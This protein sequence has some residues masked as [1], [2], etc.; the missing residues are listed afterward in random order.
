MIFREELPGTAAKRPIYLAGML[1]VLF[2][3]GLVLRHMKDFYFGIYFVLGI[4]AVFL[5]AY[6]LTRFLLFVLKRLKPRRLAFRQAVKG[7][8]RTGSAS[9][10]IIIT[11][12]SSQ[13]ATA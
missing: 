2:F 6:L 9:N 7:L 10:A 8:F 13:T 1:L 5:A 12:V 11:L 4:A 3:S